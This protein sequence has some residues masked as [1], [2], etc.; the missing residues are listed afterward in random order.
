LVLRQPIT[1][2]GQDQSAPWFH[3]L[4]KLPLFYNSIDVW[5][6]ISEPISILQHDSFLSL[7]K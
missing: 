1:K 5:D 4:E 2:P 7:S 6:W 3:Q